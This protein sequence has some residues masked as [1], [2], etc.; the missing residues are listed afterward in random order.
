MNTTEHV[1][2]VQQYMDTITITPNDHAQCLKWENVNNYT[3]AT[4]P[5]SN[6]QP[7]D[8]IHGVGIFARE[9]YEI[10]GPPSV[11]QVQSLSIHW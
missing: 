7:T 1:S 6:G 5:D 10:C 3:I 11:K 4:F 9:A 2:L 8:F